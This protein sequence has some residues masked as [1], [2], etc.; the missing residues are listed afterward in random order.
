M[1]N[2]SSLVYSYLSARGRQFHA[3]ALFSLPLSLLI[4]HFRFLEHDLQVDCSGTE[5][6]F[7]ITLNLSTKE[8]LSPSLLLL[9]FVMQSKAALCQVDP[10]RFLFREI[11]KEKKQPG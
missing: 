4:S 9:L 3:V 11:W 10:S 8:F 7:K 5:N 6:V 1:S 2:V